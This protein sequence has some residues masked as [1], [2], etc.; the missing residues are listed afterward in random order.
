MAHSWRV[1][2]R[3]LSLDPPLI[4]GVVNVTPDSF[5]DGGMFLSP[6]AAIAHARQL[7]ND[8]A[9]I[10][11]MGAESTRPGAEPVSAD[12]EWSRLEPVLDG[13]RELRNEGAVISVD[14]T[15]LD[16][17]RRAV[18]AGAAII[19]DVSALR[20]DPGIAELAARTGVGLVL[21]HMRGTPRTMQENTRYGDVAGE[22]R[23]FLERALGQA[24]Q[25]GCDPAQIAIDPGIGFG[26]D[27]AGNLELLARIGELADLGAPVWVGV[28]RKRFLGDL[29]GTPPDDRLAGTIA[30]SLEAVRSG[31]TAVRVHDV[32]EM[33]HALTV[34]RAI[35][36]RREAA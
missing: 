36:G 6:P 30:A 23:S 4:A 13:L 3:D 10:L 26:K 15:K 35:Q 9:D 22:V 19:N 17:A 29:L 5:S 25:A 8:G 14:T 16:V 31:A 34:V 1:G 2:G 7:L 18:E 12:E 32:R 28:S 27:L 21:M 24:V 11:D 20:H 33:R